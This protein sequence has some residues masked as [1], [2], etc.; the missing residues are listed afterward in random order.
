MPARAAEKAMKHVGP[1]EESSDDNASVRD[2]V[3]NGT[4]AGVSTAAWHIEFCDLAVRVPHKAVVHA[5]RVDIIS[6]D[7]ARIAD[8]TREGAF[9]LIGTG[10]RDVKGDKVG[11]RL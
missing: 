4:L 2:A 5:I 7:H 9:V 1:I 8:L 3:W 11:F 10:A 6:D